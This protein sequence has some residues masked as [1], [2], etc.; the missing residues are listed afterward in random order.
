MQLV[1]CR[2]LGGGL[3]IGKVKRSATDGKNTKNSQS[4]QFCR[5]QKF[6]HHTVGYASVYASR[7][8]LVHMGQRSL[9]HASSPS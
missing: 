4:T 8:E 7:A 2:H 5:L 6:V 9:L 3:Q 1:E